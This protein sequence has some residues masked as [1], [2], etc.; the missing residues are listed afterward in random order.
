MVVKWNCVDTWFKP[1]SFSS[2]KTK[3][4]AT[5]L[6]KRELIIVSDDHPVY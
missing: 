4:L 2:T 3:K 6:L 1:G 5:V